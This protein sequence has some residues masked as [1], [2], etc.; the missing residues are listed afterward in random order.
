MRI[1]DRVSI[2]E[3]ISKVDP[4]VREWKN[5]GL[6]SSFDFQKGVLIVEEGKWNERERDEKAKIIIQLARYCAKKNNSP[7]WNLKVVGSRSKATI[8]E[9]G[10]SGLMIQ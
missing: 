2:P 6:V 10:P 1:I 7:N 3:D 9:M 8:G 4:I 5:E